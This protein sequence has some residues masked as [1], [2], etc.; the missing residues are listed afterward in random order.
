MVEFW[1]TTFRI[2]TARPQMRR[3]ISD[4]GENNPRRSATWIRF[5]RSRRWSA[6]SSQQRACICVRG[7]Q[8]AYRNALP[9]VTPFW[10]RMDSSYLRRG[11]TIVLWNSRYIK[12]LCWRH[13]S[14]LILPPSFIWN[15]C[16]MI[17]I[18]WPLRQPISARREAKSGLRRWSAGLS[19][20]ACP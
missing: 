1:P 19:W 3:K 4:A 6:C 9:F 18:S 2:M 16:W 10:H 14:T 7:R 11:L 15:V 8:L 5:L 17:G 12:Q 13:P 20:R